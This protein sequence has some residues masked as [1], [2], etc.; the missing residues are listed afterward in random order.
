MT[1]TATVCGS[2]PEVS[3]TGDEHVAK[4]TASRRSSLE[5][6]FEPELI[7]CDMETSRPSTAGLGSR[8]D[9][10]S[11]DASSTPAIPIEIPQMITEDLYRYDAELEGRQASG[12]FDVV[13]QSTGT[14]QLGNNLGMAD[15]GDGMALVAARSGE[16]ANNANSSSQVSRY[17]VEMLYFSTEAFTYCVC[18]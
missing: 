3:T 8:S 5:S 18:S 9:A 1:S 13:R 4:V 12:H 10:A 2:A 6:A 16:M 11:A 14:S 15:R 17:Y 7:Q